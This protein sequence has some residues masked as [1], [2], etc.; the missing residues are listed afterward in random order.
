MPPPH[1]AVLAALLA[2]LGCGDRHADAP[3]RRCLAALLSTHR[4]RA[5]A[6]RPPARAIDM[7]LSAPWTK[8]PRLVAELAASDEETATMAAWCADGVLR[9][10]GHATPAR[11]DLAAATAA[12]LVR[13][14]QIATGAPVEAG[15]AAAVRAQVAAVL[16]DRKVRHMPAEDLQGCWELCVG[17]EAVFAGLRAA[18]SG[19]ANAVSVQFAAHAALAG[20]LQ[21]PGDA[22]AL[23]DG[24]FHRVAAS[25][26]GVAGPESR[27]TGG[28][29][30][31]D[32]TFV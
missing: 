24:G 11:G 12:L 30:A 13:L 15:H 26:D 19:G 14:W 22:F 8:L 1:Q 23:G 17:L 20:L 27:R 21:A 32:Q 2:L 18:A 31:C 10:T 16:D 3:W 7:A 9:A 6:G 5:A 4:G 28:D 25:G 29:A